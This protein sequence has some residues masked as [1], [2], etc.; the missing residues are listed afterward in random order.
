MILPGKKKS[1]KNRCE[2]K[3]H[4][5]V[6]WGPK[7]NFMVGGRYTVYTE[8]ACRGW[9]RERYFYAIRDNK[10]SLV[11]WWPLNCHLIPH[12]FPYFYELKSTIHVYACFNMNSVVCLHWNAWKNPLNLH[13]CHH[14]FCDLVL[15]IVKGKNCRCF[16]QH[17]HITQNICTKLTFF[18]WF[19][20]VIDEN[21]YQLNIYKLFIL[22]N[23][24]EMLW[25]S[26]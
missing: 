22:R 7:N 4:M 24:L 11:N 16:C 6:I 18:S 19:S 20:V 1:R 17:T 26:F 3:R 2:K 8:H 15:F 25:D 10:L 12:I 9:T 5:F 21:L 23:Y 13:W 14:L